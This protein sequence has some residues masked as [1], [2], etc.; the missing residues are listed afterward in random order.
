MKKRLFALLL[1]LVM[2]LGLTVIAS[3]EETVTYMDAD[4]KLQT[5]TD[6]VAISSSDSSTSF[7]AGW[8]VINGNVTINGD[9]GMTG[10][11]HLI[12]TDGCSLTV[13]GTLNVSGQGA[14]LTI[15]GQSRGTGSL[16]ATGA[17]TDMESSGIKAQKLTINGGTVTG[18]GGNG[19]AFSCGIYSVTDLTINGG[20]VTGTGGDSTG[21]DAVSYGVYSGYG[22][23][24]LANNASLTA[25]GGT[26]TT[27]YGVYLLGYSQDFGHVTMT[28]GTLI[29]KTTAT[30][31]NT[32][33]AMQVKSFTA[34]TDPYWWRT[35]ESG[36]FTKSPDTP[37]VYGSN[38]E[39]TYT[40]ITT[41]DPTP[42]AVPDA[43][44]DG[45]AA[46]AHE[47]IRR[48]NT[49]VTQEA[50]APAADDAA[51]VEAVASPKTF[52]AGVAVYGAMAVLSLG[53]SAWIAGKKRR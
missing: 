48:Q 36:A 51:R 4:G 3:A 22:N 17:D 42:P 41:V 21:T 43:P 28:S 39:A 47:T 49:S 2:A 20:T 8:Y 35:T 6:R 53:G 26:A 16:V 5:K 31:S 25:T 18:K 30:G 50:A 29:A 23:L 11:V 14:G 46:P 1:A 15:Y 38:S 7:G 44:E 45:A 32:A 33:G 10:D 12:L 9:L 40:E 19:C 52:D 24:T 37:Y 34:P 13:N 27:S